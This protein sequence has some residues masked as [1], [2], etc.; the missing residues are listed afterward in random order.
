MN[1]RLTVRAGAMGALLALVG[2]QQQEAPRNRATEVA[3]GQAAKAAE[4]VAS[5]GTDRLAITV[6]GQK[7]SASGGVW[8]HVRVVQ[9]GKNIAPS[10]GVCTDPGC[11][12]GMGWS[13]TD[14][15][16]YVYS[17]TPAVGA[18]T[19]TYT[20]DKSRSPTLVFSKTDVSGNVVVNWQ[21]IERRYDLFRAKGDDTQPAPIEL[22]QALPEAY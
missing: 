9:D 20:L 1:S 2:C 14:P 8:A 3:A 19:L 22:A 5:S 6:D 10:E 7:N 17:F 4:P 18:K 16:V 21:G 15:G 12:P 13:Q 11:N